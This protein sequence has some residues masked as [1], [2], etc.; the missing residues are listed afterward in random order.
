MEMSE[1]IEYFERRIL[2]QI[3][4]MAFVSEMVVPFARVNASVELQERHQHESTVLND[5]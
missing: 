2:R 4:S 1:D 5:V 3:F